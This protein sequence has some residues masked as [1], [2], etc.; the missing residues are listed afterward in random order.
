MRQ[1][2]VWRFLRARECFCSRKRHVETPKERQKWGESRAVG[3]GAG[4][5]PAYGVSQ[6]NSDIGQVYFFSSPPPTFPSFTLAHTLKGL[7]FL[8]SPIFLWHKIKDGGYNNTNLY[9]QLS[10]TQNTP[11]LQARFLCIGTYFLLFLCSPQR[12]YRPRMSQLSKA[13]FKQSLLE[14]DSVLHLKQTF[15]SS[16]RPHIRS[17]RSHKRRGISSRFTQRHS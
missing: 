17:L 10:P 7:L 5:V 1:L 8:L 3:E 15:L 4:R 14:R 13:T 12:G 16:T 2:T 9:K 11:A 6:K